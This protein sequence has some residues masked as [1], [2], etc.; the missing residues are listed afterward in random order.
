MMLFI[1]GERVSYREICEDCESKSRKHCMHARVRVRE[2]ACFK[3]C[4]L[5]RLSLV[6]Q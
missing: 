5:S 6:E 3:E 2:N 1:R 4:L